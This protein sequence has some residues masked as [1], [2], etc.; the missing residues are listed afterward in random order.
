MKK[1][2]KEAIEIYS[3]IED[4]LIELCNKIA[5]DRDNAATQYT[6]EVGFIMDIDDYL[7]KKFHKK[8]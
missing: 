1:A 4:R 7:K 3:A 6:Y 8:K 2:S 5:Q